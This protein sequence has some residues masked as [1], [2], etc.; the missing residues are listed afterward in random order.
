MNHEKKKKKKSLDY[1][2]SVPSLAKPRYNLSS[3]QTDKPYGLNYTLSYGLIVCFHLTLHMA[4][5]HS[6]LHFF[7]FFQFFIFSPLSKRFV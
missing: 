1:P 4:R 6:L 5:L 3:Q 2:L 7:F